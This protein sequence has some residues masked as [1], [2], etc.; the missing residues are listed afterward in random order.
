MCTI[1]ILDQVIDSGATVLKIEGRSKGPDYVYTV[2]K[3]YRQAI[4]AIVER[5]Y[6]SG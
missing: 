6:K 3:A 1:D 5:I 2:T 4:D